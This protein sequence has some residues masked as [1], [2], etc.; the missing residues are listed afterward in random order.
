MVFIMQCGHCLR[1]AIMEDEW[2][3]SEIECPLCAQPIHLD[4]AAPAAP[5]SPAEGP[6]PPPLVKARPKGPA[7]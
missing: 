4:P 1:Y 3:G 5:E 7:Q 6:Q 2:C